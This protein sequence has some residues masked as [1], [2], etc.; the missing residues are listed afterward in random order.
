MGKLNWPGDQNDK[1]Q[2]RITKTQLGVSATRIKEF[3]NKVI[4][5]F[6]KPKVERIP[7]LDLVQP[8]LNE[9]LNE[10]LVVN[11]ICDPV[12]RLLSDFTHVTDDHNK[13]ADWLSGKEL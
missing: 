13:G 2:V 10:V 3:K 8:P 11:I 1:S 5:E 4:A 6:N 9:W 7:W 12:K